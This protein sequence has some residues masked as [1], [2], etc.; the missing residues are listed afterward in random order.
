MATVETATTVDRALP[1]LGLR[2]TAGPIELRGI[3][4]D[5]IIPLAGLVIEGI[6][7]PGEMPFL[8][9]WELGPPEKMPRIIAQREWKRRAGF[10]PASW[11]ADL[12]VFWN[13][14]LVGEQSIFATDYLIT[15]TAET[16]SW[17][18]RRAQGSGIG[19]VMRQVVCA[20]AFDYLD[21]A[22]LTSIAFTDNAASRAVSR[23][24]GY[25]ENGIESLARMGKPVMGQRFLLEPGRL[26]RYEHPVTVVGLGAFR[27][28][29]G[30]GETQA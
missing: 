21:A 15:R 25:T 12:G 30:L 22:Y 7:A 16:G 13:G 14:E 5:M 10:S 18:S 6:H 27:R 9:S 2:I 11:T 20:F 24:V 19:T 1:V 23:K 17:L 3:T 29:I 8:S 28:S 4:D 26:V